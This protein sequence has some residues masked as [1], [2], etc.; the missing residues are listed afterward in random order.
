MTR[1]TVFS[2]GVFDTL[3]TYRTASVR[4]VL[5]ALR[6]ALHIQE[7]LGLPTRLVEEFLEVRTTA[8]Y[9]V[10]Y[11]EG[12]EDEEPIAVRLDE[13]YARIAQRYPE[14]DPALIARI[15]QLEVEIT[16]EL[17]IGIPENIARVH[18]LLDA[19]ER[20]VLI[21]DTDFTGAEVE[22]LLAGIDARLAACPCYVASDLG[23]T[24]RSGELFRHVLQAEGVA[25]GQLIH[26]GDDVRAD[27]RMPRAMGIAAERY[28]GALLSEIEWASHEEDSLFCQLLAGSSKT[29]RILHP[30]ASPHALIGAG[31][32]GPLF[33]GF[34]RDVLDQ[35][36]QRGI[37]RLYFIARDGMIFLR[38]ARAIARE[39][40]LDLDLRYL[41]GSR[42]AFRLPSVFEITPREHRWLAERIPMLSLAML[43]E[44]V[45]MT[46][47][48][49]HALLPDALRARLSDLDASIP[50]PLTLELLEHFDEIPA[51]REAI[52]DNARRARE[53][54]IAYLQQE[55]F[56]DA[57]PV[58]TVDIGWMGGSQDSLYKIAASHKPDIEIHGFYF[59]LFHYSHYTSARNRKTAYAIRPNHVEDNIVALH[60]ELL[61]QADHGQT[62]GYERRPD[63]R[64]VPKLRDDGGHLRDWGVGE[65]L[66][67]AEWFATEYA[68]LAGR[69]PLLTEHFDAVLPRL[70]E[71]MH[72]PP[73]LIAETLGRVPYSG[74]HC[75]LALRESAPA[76][77]VRE[78]FDYAF[79]RRYED[80]RLMTEWYEASLVRSAPLARLI[81]RL[82]PLSQ[83][84]KVLVKHSVLDSLK[85]T[86]TLRKHLRRFR[87]ERATGRR[88]IRDLSAARA[89]ER[90]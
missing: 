46:G 80:R 58:G 33:Y 19:G 87:Q 9:Q 64:I 76:F 32:A 56:F 47:E 15:R 71:L 74:D 59:G 18:R 57:G 50:E 75:D 30:D 14:L 28:K 78:A 49:L 24:K 53:L 12:T 72:K 61:A 20:V 48:Q 34:I 42:R 2:F 4:G 37:R 21:S 90:P 38:L 83:G 5:C 8:D 40:G 13:I 60:T 63:G 69:Y 10:R 73:R 17:L 41:Y 23:L 36:C 45:D 31:L 16:A 85:L 54:L 81:L 29:Y 6:H 67:G 55:D 44:R 86:R 51:I 84:L 35:A 43:A 22:H 79:R 52:L 3:V 27:W 1:K 77:G 68:R 66:D 82:H 25:P 7:E 39:R 11:P 65:F 88:L 62:V 26:L 89:S 70:F